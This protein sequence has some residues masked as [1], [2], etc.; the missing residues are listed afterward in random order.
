MLLSDT[1]T[2]QSKGRSWWASH[3]SQAKKKCENAGTTMPKS[4]KTSHERHAVQKFDWSTHIHWRYDLK[5]CNSSCACE[6]HLMNFALRCIKLSRVELL[7]A[8]ARRRRKKLSC[9]KRKERAW[10]YLYKLVMI[11]D[12]FKGYF[13]QCVLDPMTEGHVGYNEQTIWSVPCFCGPNKK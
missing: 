8:M 5:L 4:T 2:T 12:L 1:W 3:V 11:L 7:S 10:I 6:T 9:S 13:C